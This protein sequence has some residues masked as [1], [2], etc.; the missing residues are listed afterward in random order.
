MEYLRFAAS[1]AQESRQAGRLRAVRS[2][3]RIA[4]DQRPAVGGRRDPHG[5]R[6]L[7]SAAVSQTS[8]DPM[9]KI[10]SWVTE[11]RARIAA[12]AP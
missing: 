7:T 2:A 4:D 3:R 1:R 6:L 9:A 12:L 5:V 11:Q 10:A 8:A